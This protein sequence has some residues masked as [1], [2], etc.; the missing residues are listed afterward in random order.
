M[1]SVVG[2][3]LKTMNQENQYF[4]FTF[5]LHL[6]CYNCWQSLQGYFNAVHLSQSTWND[7][8]GDDDERTKPHVTA[9]NA[10]LKRDGSVGLMLCSG[11]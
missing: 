10:R 6:N 4:S 5:S 7:D 2:V 1:C 9:L 11:D 3:N 8:D